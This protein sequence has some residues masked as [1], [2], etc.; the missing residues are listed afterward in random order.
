MEPIQHIDKARHL[1]GRA[2]FMLKHNMLDVAGREAYLAAMHAACAYVTAKNGKT[3]RT[4]GGTQV[5]FSR[6][7]RD[8]SRINRDYVR[9]LSLAYELKQT[10]DYSEVQDC[11]IEEIE[12]AIITATA[13]VN[14]IADL[15][16]K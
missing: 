8:D 10:A 13:M 3:P 9:F 14:A 11:N 5:E 2:N 6:L 4:H 1:L 16:E 15:F 12:R 7:A